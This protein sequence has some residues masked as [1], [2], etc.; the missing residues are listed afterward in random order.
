V[1]NIICYVMSRSTPATALLLAGPSS[2]GKTTLAAALQR[3]LPE[4]W[5]FLP[6]DLLTDGFPRARPEFISAEMDRRLRH[7]ALLALAAFM[8]SGFN[9]IGE[10]Y[11]WDPGMRE[12]TASV[13][14]H[15][16]AFI[17]KLQCD[18]R[19]R[20]QREAGRPITKGFTRMQ[21]RQ[22]NWDFPHDLALDTDETRP[23]DLAATVWA[24]LNS[25]PLPVALR[26]E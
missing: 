12:L 18:L 5:V 25:D 7:A 13:F 23:E 21:E 19:I 24:W 15:R 2:A 14:S 22:W 4:P 11:V 26:T 6:A 1:A 3:M 17:V 9:V 20:E 10:A 16:R 8:D